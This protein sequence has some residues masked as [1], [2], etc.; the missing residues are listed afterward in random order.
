M[1]IL[2]RELRLKAVHIS[3]LEYLGN[4]FHYSVKQGENPEG[5]NYRV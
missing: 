1:E 4:L 5:I 2:S 3:K